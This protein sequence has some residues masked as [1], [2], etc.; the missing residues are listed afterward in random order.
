MTVNTA[1]L[2]PSN[3]QPYRPPILL[4]WS[5]RNA[6]R[7]SLLSIIAA[8]VT[9]DNIAMPSYLGYVR[10]DRMLEGVVILLTLLRW[11]HRPLVVRPLLLIPT[12]LV[13]YQVG[14]HG[15]VLGRLREWEFLTE[16]ISYSFYMV[17]LIA[18]SAIWA[19]RQHLDWFNRAVG[20]MSYAMGAIGVLQFAIANARGKS[21]YLLPESMQVRFGWQEID[22]TRFRGLVRGVG[23]ATE[24]SYYGSGMVVLLALCLTSMMLVPRTGMARLFQWGAVLMALVGVLISVSV[25][26]WGLAILVIG[27]WFAMQVEWRGVVPSLRSRLSRLQ[28]RTVRVALIVVVLAGIAAGVAL[29]PFLTSRIQRVQAGTDTSANSRVQLSLDLIRQPS[30]TLAGSFIGTG[31]GLIADADVV[32][33]GYQRHGL[34]YRKDADLWNGYSYYAVT[35]GYIGLALI[36]WLVWTVVRVPNRTGVPLFHLTVLAI[37]YPAAHG[38]LIHWYAILILVWVI[39]SIPL[40]EGS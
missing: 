22:P 24:P 13:L 27:A 18:G 28:R 16:V 3:V 20:L 8:G 12:L 6:L 1:Q 15:V 7:L 23:L 10:I 29:T 9:Y 25:A 39:R 37:F 17:F 26:A 5:G 35:G 30:D 34:L 31:V 11:M 38:V 2:Q 40:S 36:L 14:L 33:D 19:Q 21:W 32:W 4:V